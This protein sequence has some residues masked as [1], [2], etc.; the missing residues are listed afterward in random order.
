MRGGVDSNFVATHSE[1][2]YI[3][4]GIL[5]STYVATYIKLSIVGEKVDDRLG[6]LYS[7]I[8]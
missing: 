1:Y 6:I 4:L 3:R 7:S 8:S 5:Y 2:L